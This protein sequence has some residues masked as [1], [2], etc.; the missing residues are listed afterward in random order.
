MANVRYPGLRSTGTWYEHAKMVHVSYAARV[1]F[2]QCWQTKPTL[3]CDHRVEGLSYTG[4]VGRA[5][6]RIE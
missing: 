3:L 5:G 6:S 4:K 2:V 1:F